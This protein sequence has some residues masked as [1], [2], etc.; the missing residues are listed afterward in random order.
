MSHSNRNRIEDQQSI[1]Q[2]TLV[3]QYISIPVDDALIRLLGGWD[4]LSSYQLYLSDTLSLYHKD[5]VASESTSIQG[6]ARKLI[7]KYVISFTENTPGVLKRI[8]KKEE[9]NRFFDSPTINI[10]EL[11]V[12]FD[13]DEQSYLRFKRNEHANVPHYYVLNDFYDPGK[14]N[15]NVR[16]EYEGQTWSAYNNVYLVLH[17]EKDEYETLQSKVARGRLLDN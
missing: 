10:P 9:R 17:F 8:V 13:I 16:A 11:E 2:D 4:K 1:E 6:D 15:V 5:E 12:Y 7:D 3:Q 14:K